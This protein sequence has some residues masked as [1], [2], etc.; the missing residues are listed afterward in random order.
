MRLKNIT[1]MVAAIATAAS[2]GTVAVASADAQTVTTGD[3]TITL[4]AQTA[5]QLTGHTFKAVKIASYDVYGTE[6]NQSVTL[7]TEDDVKAEVV[8]PPRATTP[9]RTAT[10]SP[11]RSS[12]TT[13]SST[14]PARARG[15]ETAPPAALPMHSHLKRRAP[16]LRSSTARPPHSH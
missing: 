9:R 3:A 4:N 15:S 2:L 7:R 12:K 16:S 10:R 14:S 13:P 11:G 1:A 8:S 6:P 5:G